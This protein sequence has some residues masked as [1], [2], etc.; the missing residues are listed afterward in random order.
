MALGA[1]APIFYTSNDLVKSEAY[2]QV[3]TN[4]VKKI[5]SS[6]VDYVKA[7]YSVL[8]T[9]TESEIISG[10][11]I[12][13]NTYTN[14]DEL[15]ALLY[16]EWANYAMGNY[17]PATSGMKS[18][19]TRIESGSI[20]DGLKIWHRFFQPNLNRN[21]CLDMSEY[22]PMGVNA[23]IHC[24]DL[25]GCG[26]GYDGESWDYQACS[27]NIEP[28]STNNETDMFPVYEWSMDWLDNHCMSRFKIKA[29]TRQ[30]WMET[31]FGLSSPYFENKFAEITSRIIFSNG[32]QDGWSAGGVLK[33][34]SESLIAIV[35]PNGAHHSDMRGSS[36]Y[37]TQDIKDAREQER[38]IL[39]QWIKEVQQQNTKLV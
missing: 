2:Y 12:C 27:Q 6:C 38:N 13:S 10:I 20:N 16:E 33:N 39:K 28:F 3:V 19:C 30:S 34:M 24:S 36:S 22:V 26:S 18:A 23:T 14:L 4:A 8:M 1:S 17:P 25:T 9:S 37:D 11:P 32:E 7:A 31:E 15:Q 35:I 5:S 21:G 29:S